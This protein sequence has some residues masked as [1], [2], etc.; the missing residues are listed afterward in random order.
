MNKKFCSY[1]VIIWSH[2]TIIYNTEKPVFEHLCIER[3]HHL[4]GKSQFC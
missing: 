1:N 4:R 2:K 3:K